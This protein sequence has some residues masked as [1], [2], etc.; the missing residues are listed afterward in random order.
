MDALE[1]S[2]FLRGLCERRTGIDALKLPKLLIGHGRTIL[3]IND[4]LIP[5]S[6]CFDFSDLFGTFIIQ[7]QR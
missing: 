1:S 5:G 2:K 4:V 3:I 7:K 6:T